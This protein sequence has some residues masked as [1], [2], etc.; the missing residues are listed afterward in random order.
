MIDKATLVGA[1]LIALSV[2]AFVVVI[3]RLARRPSFTFSIKG[4][5][6]EISVASQDKDQSC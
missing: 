2:C 1:C 4:L 5:G 6:V 3:L